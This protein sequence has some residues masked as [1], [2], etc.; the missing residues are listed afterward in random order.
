MQVREIFQ[1]TVQYELFS[2]V[3]KQIR[4]LEAFFHI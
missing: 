2:N 3:L 4:T 1:E